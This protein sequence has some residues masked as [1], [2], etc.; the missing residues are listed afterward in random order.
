M[1]DTLAMDH[2]QKE[3]EMD[4]TTQDRTAHV[5]IVWGPTAEWGDGRGPLATFLSAEQAA[6]YMADEISSVSEMIAEFTADGEPAPWPYSA[7]PGDFYVVEE[8]IDLDADAPTDPDELEEYL[9][10]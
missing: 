2:G 7:D 9:S 5:F 10:A 8:D 1:T 3:D 6:L 4:S